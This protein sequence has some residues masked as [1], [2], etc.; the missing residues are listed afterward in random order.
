MNKLAMKC[1]DCS[2]QFAFKDRRQH[3]QRCQVP[4]I[5]AQ[6]NSCSRLVYTCKC[7]PP[8]IV[9]SDSYLCRRKAFKGLEAVKKPD[10]ER[11]SL[12]STG[13]DMLQS[14]LNE[15]KESEKD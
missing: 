4:N 7:C 13:L 5:L 3:M 11:F 12:F 6:L 15:R 1:Q 14:L 10:D 2:E 9:K 8:I